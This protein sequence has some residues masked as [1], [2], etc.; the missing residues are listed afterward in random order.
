MTDATREGLI[1]SNPVLR[2]RSGRRR[3]AG[4][5]IRSHSDPLTPAEI[6]AFLATVPDAYRTFYDVWFRLGWRSS[7]M[8]GLR[9]RNLAFPRQIITVGT[10]RLPRLR[11]PEG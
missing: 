3:R 2:I 10:G 1:S 8:V 11:G 5:R 9:V 4:T 6:V 7:G